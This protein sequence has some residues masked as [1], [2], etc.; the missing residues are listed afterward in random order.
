MKITL[1]P[2][3]GA[4]IGGWEIIFLLLTMFCFVAVTTGI[5]VAVIYFTN[6]SAKTRAG[7]SPPAAPA[8]KIIPLLCPQCGTPLPSGALAGLCPACLLKMGAA[9]DTV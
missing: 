1:E 6:R 2:M 3:F 7:G 4:F 9:T 8:T 5:V